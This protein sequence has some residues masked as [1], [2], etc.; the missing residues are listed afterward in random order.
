MEGVLDTLH[1]NHI[2][3]KAIADAMSS[4]VSRMTQVIVNAVYPQVSRMT[5]VGITSP[6]LNLFIIF[7]EKKP[8]QR[9]T[10]Y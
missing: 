2:I 5:Q 9:L 8:H 3:E 6:S 7:H 10:L 4:H 1:I